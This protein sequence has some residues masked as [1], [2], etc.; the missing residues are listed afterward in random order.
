M[1][2][3]DSAENR[4]ILSI[5]IIKQNFDGLIFFDNSDI[6]RKSINLFISANFIEVPFFGIKPIETNISC[7]SL[8]VKKDKFLSSFSS[9]WVKYPFLK[10]N[11]VDNLWD[12]F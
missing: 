5:E 2:L 4:A 6:Y 3:I 10:N 11:V 8:L 7:T 9:N 1:I 12:K